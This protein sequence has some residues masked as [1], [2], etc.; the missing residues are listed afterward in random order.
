MYGGGDGGSGDDSAKGIVGHT[1]HNAAHFVA[2]D[3]LQALSD[4]VAIDSLLTVAASVSDMA[5]VGKDFTLLRISLA[6]IA[7][8]ALPYLAAQSIKRS[9]DHFELAGI[10]HGLI[11]ALLVFT[12]L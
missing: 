3:L 4:K 5:F 12:A 1:A 11:M 9:S 2:S 8:A 7:V 10:V 6:G